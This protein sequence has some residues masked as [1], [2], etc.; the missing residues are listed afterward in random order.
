MEC[1][2]AS[3]DSGTCEGEAGCIVGLVC[4]VSKRQGL[5]AMANGDTAVPTPTTAK[6]QP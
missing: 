2:A 4:R 1:L 6:G 3:S 5:A